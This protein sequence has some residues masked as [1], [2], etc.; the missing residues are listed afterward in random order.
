MKVY[1]K[2][3]E[4]L[5]VD[6]RLARREDV[7]DMI[8][9]LIKQHGNYYQRTDLYSMDFFGQAIEKKDLYMVVAELADGLV[10]GMTGANGK[11]EFAGALEWIM[12]TIRPSCRG[13]GM[14]KHL[15]SHL[16]QA[17]PPELYTCVY[18]RCMS[19]DTVSQKILAG[20]GHR[21]TG[22]LF[23]CYRVDAHAE[24]LSGMTLPFK[25]NLILTCLPGNK[26]DAGPL[27]APPA[28][29]GYIRGVYETL[30][31]AYAL[32]EG[33]G[34]PQGD[35]SACAVTPM[36]DH[37]YCE[38]FAEGVGLDFKGILENALNRYGALE[39]QSFNALIN[40]N[41]PAAPWAGDLL[42]DRG[43]FFAGVHALSGPRE[44]MIFHYSPALE[45]PFDQIAVLPDFAETFSYIK[46][47]SRGK[48]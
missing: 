15:I 17:L 31:V 40:L 4:E 24:N 32:R 47:R 19:L 36:E 9:L 2:R 12:L 46:D 10:A 6:I 14:G 37:R 48:R 45:V 43:F 30:G 28:H 5:E 1:N 29:A 35:S 7:P 38:L 20:L 21:I 33:G 8:S 26:K 18:G 34:K 23:N 44:Y 25:H 41:D 39:G 11:T 13:Y 27:Y 42:E 3:R 16:Q 22:A